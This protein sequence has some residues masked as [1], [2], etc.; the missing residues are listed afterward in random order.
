M[1]NLSYTQA[2]FRVIL[3]SDYIRYTPPSFNLV[4]GE[5]NQIF[6]DI[7]REDSSISLKGSYFELDFIVTHR[8]GAHAWYADGDHIKL[9][10]LGPL[11]YLIKL[12]WL[13]VVE[14]R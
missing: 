9:V 5:K 11:P 13:V 1:F 3:K 7:P 12:D 14:K 2:V 8:A 4:N 6:I 10:N